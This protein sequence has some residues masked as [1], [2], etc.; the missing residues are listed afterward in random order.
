MG[1][2]VETLTSLTYMAVFAM[3]YYGPNASIMGTIKLSIFQYKAVSDLGALMQTLA[4]FWFV[5]FCSF[6]LNGMLLYCTCKINVL[7]VMKGLHKDFWFYF[8]VTEATLLLNVSFSS[9][10]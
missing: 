9:I 4:F 1:E 7:T 10:D 2:R 5:G 8:M 3:S 6:L